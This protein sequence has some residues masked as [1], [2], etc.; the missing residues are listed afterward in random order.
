MR[1]FRTAR[2]TTRLVEGLM[3]GETVA[4]TLLPGYC[5]RRQKEART[6]FVRK[7]AHGRRHYVG[8]GDHGRAG[9]TEARARQAALLLIAA[10]KQGRDPA[11]E[12]A[13]Q[14]GM[15]TLAAFAEAFLER[16]NET[17]KKGTLAVY[18]CMLNKHVAPRDD[19]DVVKPGCLGRL[20]LDQVTRPMLSALHRS[21]RTT[22]R[23]ANHILDILSSIY[24]EA[25]RESLVGADFNP[26]SPIDRFRIQPRQRFL[27]ELELA[28]L[29]KTLAEVEAECSEDPFAIAA[30][31]LLLLTGCR[32]DEILDARWDWIDMQ[33]GL[34]MLPDSK[35]GAKSV[36]L[37]SGRH[38][39][40]AE[41]TKSR[42]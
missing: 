22:P 36:L 9:M 10:L 15:P 14:R 21:L 12:R 18:R 25:Q 1:A 24:G 16:R 11:V 8:L 2:I 4:D 17:L 34:L 42:G 35:T 23:A 13:R 33:R 40:L 27:T 19:R 29:G 31:R 6:Y 41:A 3:P 28:R 5:V 26:T 37:K 39:S 38:R 32:R 20:R 7:Y 30:L